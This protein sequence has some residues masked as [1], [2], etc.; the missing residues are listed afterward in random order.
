MIRKYSSNEFHIVS[1]YV[2]SLVVSK[3]V[4][5]NQRFPVRVQLLPMCRGICEAGGSGSEELKKCPSPSLAVLWF[6]NGC[7]RKSR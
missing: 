4:L 6:M 3:H 7:E 1:I 2:C 5:G